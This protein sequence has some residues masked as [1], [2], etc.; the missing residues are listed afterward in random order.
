MALERFTWVGLSENTGLPRFIQLTNQ[1]LARWA[2]LL[3][4]M[5][6]RKYR[7]ARRR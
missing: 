7:A 1:R 5:Q 4:R 2:D 6:R 3:T